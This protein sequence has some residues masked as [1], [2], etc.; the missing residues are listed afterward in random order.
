MEGAPSPAKVMCIIGTRPEAVKM[1]PVVRELKQQPGCLV[2]VVATA[3]HREL[4]DQALGFFGIEPDIDLDLMRPGQSL[5]ELVGRA[6]LGLD[7]VLRDERPDIVLA[8]G[9]TTS[10]LAAALC[11][12]HRQIAF[13]HVE[14][15]LRTGDRLAPFPEEMNRV[16]T[17][18]LA[19]LHFAPTPAARD[20]LLREGVAARSIHV[21]GNTVIDALHWALRQELPPLEDLTGKRVILVTAHRRESFGPPLEQI[22]LAVRDLAKQPAV[23]L[24]FPVHPNPQVQRQVRRCLEGVAGVRLLPPLDYPHFVAAMR[25]ADLIL[26]DSG[27]VQEEAPGLGKP[28]LVLRETT[29]RPEG[30]LCG[31]A[32]LAGTRRESIV[33]AALDVLSN[34]ARYQQ[35]ALAQCPYGDGQAAG[36]IAAAVRE[37]LASG[38]E[39]RAAA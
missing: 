15:G 36:R 35:M 13:G 6:A 37:Y 5:N 31:A 21:T 24:L 7:C 28:V 20:H 11:C 17:S 30:I 39:S 2:R 26:T 8:Q 12:F 32:C 4:L 25:A 22:C 1:A 38:R 19:A 14:A 33:A 10:V 9:D 23:E 27:G 29:E 3:Q 34:P 16:L 18:R